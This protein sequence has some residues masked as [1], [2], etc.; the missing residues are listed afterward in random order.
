M[1]PFILHYAEYAAQF[2]NFF[3][4]KLRYP[5]ERLTLYVMFI[6]VNKSTE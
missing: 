5:F 2:I 1:K 3:I 6:Q 4:D